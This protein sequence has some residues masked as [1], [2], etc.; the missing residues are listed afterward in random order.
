[1]MRKP[2]IAACLL[3]ATVLHRPA[4]NGQDPSADFV[5]RL[6]AE[7]ARHGVAPVASDPGLAA[8]A[9]RNNGLQAAYG[10]GHH[11]MAQ[12]GQ[13]AA[14]AFDGATALG[15]WL[16]SSPHAA[17]LLDPS[18]VACGF[19]CSGSWATANVSTGGFA[20]APVQARTAPMMR[21]H[22]PPPCYPMMRHRGL[23]RRQ[24]W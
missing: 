14:L 10:L 1:M 24:R 13:C 9:A 12:A 8:H 11:A 6:N 5:A 23:F 15:Q 2:L 19:A 3:S 4:A 18:A 17:I 21:G 7:R 22:V 16:A 20:P